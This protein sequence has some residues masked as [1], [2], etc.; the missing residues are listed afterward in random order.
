[1]SNPRTD[2]DVNQALTS[3]MG[4]VAPQRAPTR[5]LEE[6][7][8][9]TMRARQARAYPWHKLPVGRLGLGTTRGGI[10]IVLFVLGALIVLAIAAGLV[11]GGFRATAPS[12][13]SPSPTAGPTR[14]PNIA[15]RASL[16]APVPVTADETI[17]VEGPIAMVADSA[18]LWVM[19]AG[20]I[21]RLDP[22]VNAVTGSVTLGPTT[23]LYNGLAV[24]E[25][26]LWAT[27]SDAAVIY[28]VDPE[29]LTLAASIPAGQSP[30]GV[31]ATAAGVWVADVH[32]GA[33]LRIDP[34]T[35]KVVA[36][37]TVGPTG[38]SGPNWLAEGLDSIWVGI[39]NNTTI[40]RIDPVTNKV[41]ATIQTLLSIPPCGGLAVGTD[42]AWIT[43]CSST[44]LMAR[45]DPTSNA[46]VATLDLGGFGYNPTLMDGIPWISVN[47]GDATTGFI[48]RINPATNTIDRVL[49]PGSSFGGGGDI[50]VAFGS[51]WVVDGYYN[52]VLR[53]PQAAFAP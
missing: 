53:L 46:I 39:P 13:P 22:G 17:A 33:V 35:N 6:T 2:R 7:F 19:G 26:G 45:V 38:N 9:Q 32:G 5:L 50:V 3:W 4:E 51:V 41:Q 44:G 25:A 24:N 34:A 27:D 8:A 29:T 1:M 10:P 43:G 28:R 47:T 16:P 48:V 31:L 12:S 30:K 37:T 18:A 42:A 40:A 14:N 11:G 15:P 52:S 23:D 49:R 20:R 36:T 21:D